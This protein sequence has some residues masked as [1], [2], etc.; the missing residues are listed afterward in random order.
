M[1]K[2]ILWLYYVKIFLRFQDSKWLDPAESNLD[3]YDGDNLKGYVIEVDPEYP[4]E[5]HE[6]QNDYPLARDKLKIKKEML[7]DYQSKIA[8]DFIFILVMLKK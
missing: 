7:S 8:G 6:L 5:L 4:K 3:K 1:G 2:I